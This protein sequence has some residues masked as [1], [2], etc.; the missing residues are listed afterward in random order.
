MSILR[1]WLLSAIKQKCLRPIHLTGITAAPEQGGSRLSDVA[2]WN[3][4]G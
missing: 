4:A 3:S 2:G 1:F